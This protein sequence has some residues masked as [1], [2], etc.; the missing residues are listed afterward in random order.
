MKPM[1]AGTVEFVIGVD[2]HR[3]SH[4]AAILQAATGGVIEQLTV[5][6][7]AFGYRRLKAFADQHA[8]GA[9]VWAIEGTGSYGAG[10]TSALLEHGEWVVEIDRPARPARRDGA[11][12][13]E[14]DAVRAAREALSR[15]HLAAPRARGD[16]E[17]L[18]VLMAARQG[19]VVARTKAIGQLKAL[20]VNAPQALRDQLRRSSTDEQLQRC[21]RLRTLPSHSIEH[22]ARIRALRG[23][24]R[25][26]LALE[27]EA[28]EYETELE[29]LVVAI[30]PVLLEQ[31]GI[32]TI[33]AAQFLISWSHA[34]RVRS[35]A[36]FASLGGAAP[37]PASSGATVRH[38]LNRSGDRQL[39]RALHTVTL[40]RLRIHPPTK[41]YAARRTNEGKTPREIKRCLKRA[42]AREAYRLMNAHAS[43]VTATLPLTA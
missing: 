24:A 10:L 20:I 11:K 40:S 5:P 12:S 14:L 27:A 41:A 38:R 4:T 25:R 1:L 35:E 8:A 7:D 31:P 15:E 29:Q 2:T 9:R 23:T 13:D 6:T 19:A 17:A 28:A 42:I 39:N 16:R 43:P 37:I 18:R 3:D 32:G 30:C 26:A 22:R 33:T 34:G 36:A 21:A